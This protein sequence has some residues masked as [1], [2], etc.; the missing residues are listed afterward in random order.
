M[1]QQGFPLEVRT[2]EL[3]KAHN[4][5]VTNQAAYSDTESGK[6]RTIDLI[7]E[8]NVIEI[9][10][11]LTFDIWLFIDCKRTSKPWVFY[12]SDLDLEKEETHRK[13]VSSTQFFINNLAY[14]KGKADALNDLIVGQFLLQAKMSQPI[15]H[16]L[17]YSSFVPFTKGKG[18]SIHKARMQV[19]NAILDFEENISLSI[20]QL[21]DFPYGILFVPV[22]A[23]EGKLLVYED[24]KLDAAD[25]LYY[26]VPYHDSAFMI[27]IVKT[28]FL[29]TY[30]KNIEHLI[31]S[32]K[33]LPEWKI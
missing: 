25:G 27:E 4:W 24:G 15:F 17:A 10:S 13:V 16:K 19:C 1:E 14:Q 9:P 5:E 21:I 30:L 3:L 26:H 23:L 2:S 7:A 11:K 31:A 28:D 33:P 20:D 18:M 32:F 22:I 12:A 6:I 29:E 8:K